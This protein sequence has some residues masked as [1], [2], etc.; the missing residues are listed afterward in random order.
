MTVITSQ[1]NGIPKR[2]DEGDMSNR[3]ISPFGN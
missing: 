1:R 2:E 3:F